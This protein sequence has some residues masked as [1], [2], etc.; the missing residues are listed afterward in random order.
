MEALVPG[1]NSSRAEYKGIQVKS[2]CLT[3][4]RGRVKKMCRCHTVGQGGAEEKTG[5]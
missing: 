1:E 4:E 3:R 2:F 5:E